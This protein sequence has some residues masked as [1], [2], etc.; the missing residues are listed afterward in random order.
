MT[1]KA[2]AA[3]IFVSQYRAFNAVVKLLS[4]SAARDIALICTIKIPFF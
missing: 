3:I 4:A 1:W 2:V